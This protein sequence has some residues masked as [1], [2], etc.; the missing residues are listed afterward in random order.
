MPRTDHGALWVDGC[1]K[2]LGSDVRLRFGTTARTYK[3]FSP[4]DQQLQIHYLASLQ[5]RPDA[6]PHFL[7]VS[8]SRQAVGLRG[9]FDSN[10]C[11][12]LVVGPGD[13]PIPI[14]APCPR[15]DGLA[16]EIQ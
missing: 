16:D 4:V 7:A 2:L 15:R 5:N 12:Q 8:P 13:R 10:Q 3:R 14:T 1:G 6:L 9:D 11:R